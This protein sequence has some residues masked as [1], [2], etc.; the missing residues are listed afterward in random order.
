MALPRINPPRIP[1]VPAAPRLPTAP[2]LPTYAGPK[3]PR[4]ILRPIAYVGVALCV[5]LILAAGGW[6]TY[7]TRD[8]MLGALVLGGLIV[9][10]LLLLMVRMLWRRLRAR[11]AARLS[12]RLGKIGHERPTDARPEEIATNDDLAR[13]FEEGL[14]KFKAAGKSVYD[15]P[16]YLIVGEPGGGKTEAMRHSEIGFP[17]GLHDAMQGAGGTYSMS[18]WFSNRAVLIDTAG[19]L[20]F[21]DRDAEGAL[22]GGYRNVW[23][24]FLK[25]LRD[26][27]PGCPINGMVLV[28]PAVSLLVDPPEEIEAKGRLIRE[29][30]DQIQK[31]LGVRFPVYVVVTKCDKITGFKPFFETVDDPALQHQMLG[32]SNPDGLDAPFD[33]ESVDK[34]LDALHEKLRRRRTVALAQAATRRDVERRLDAVDELYDFPD[35]FRA[36]TDRLRRYLELAF[37]PD[38]WSQPLLLRGI[39][40][41]SSMREGDALD[42]LVSDITGVPP[43]HLPEGRSWAVDKAYFLRDVFV[44]KAFREKGLIVSGNEA[45]PSRVK[46]RHRLLVGGAAAAALAVIGGLF[47]F[48]TR[49]LDRAVVSQSSY[50]SGLSNR[51]VDDKG[52]LSFAPGDGAPTRQVLAANNSGALVYTGDTATNGQALEELHGAAPARLRESLTV[53][54]LFKLPAAALGDGLGNARNAQVR[55]REAYRAVFRGSVATPLI[56]PLLDTPAANGD[57]GADE[58]YRNAMVRVLDYERLAATA[59]KSLQSGDTAAANIALT[60]L[61]GLSLEPLWLNALG[62][63]ATMLAAVDVKAYDEAMR[64]AHG[65]DQESPSETDLAALRQT[66]V[67]FRD[68]MTPD[69]WGELVSTRL[70]GGS[71]AQVPVDLPFDELSPTAADFEAKRQALDE[72]ASRPPPKTRVEYDERATVLRDAISALNTSG[73]E[74]E[75]AQ[76]KAAGLVLPGATDL[77]GAVD[78]REQIAG[79]R[80]N[81]AR[82]AFERFT[83]AP[84]NTVAVTTWQRV[85]R[86]AQ[87]NTQEFET[88]TRAMRERLQ[89][90]P[91]GVGLAGPPD[92]PPSWRQLL[93]AYNAISSAAQPIGDLETGA[94]SKVANRDKRSDLI[95]AIA[96][97]PE[98]VSI[99]ESARTLW[100]DVI[101]PAQRHAIEIAIIEVLPDDPQKIKQLVEA[102]SRSE[103]ES[104]QTGVNRL[105]PASLPLVERGVTVGVDA[106]DPWA[107]ELVAADWG[108]ITRSLNGEGETL[109]VPYLKDKFDPMRKNGLAPYAAEYVNHWHEQLNRAATP[110]L[111][112]WP[113]QQSRGITHG[114]VKASVEQLATLYGKAGDVISRLGIQPSDLTE[115]DRPQEA[116]VRQ[117]GNELQKWNNAITAADPAMAIADPVTRW[118]ALSDDAA[119]AAKTLREQVDH[120]GFVRDYLAGNVNDPSPKERYLANATA[121]FL[122]TLSGGVGAASVTGEDVRVDLRFPLIPSTDLGAADLMSPEQ[123]RQFVESRLGSQIRQDE[124]VKK[125]AETIVSTHGEAVSNAYSKIFGLSSEELRDANSIYQW[126]KDGNR[127]FTMTL[128]S[129]NTQEE[130]FRDLRGRAAISA[131]INISATANQNFDPNANRGV[132]PTLIERASISTAGIDFSAT[133]RLG[134]GTAEPVQ[135][136]NSALSAWR[137]L[138]L[139]D[140]HGVGVEN[141]RIVH[142]EIPL[143]VGNDDLRKPLWIQVEFDAELPPALVKRFGG[144]HTP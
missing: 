42:V 10:G 110:S 78:R 3:P 121:S 22:G 18:W 117:A 70:I 12:E 73:E 97:V 65:L 118:S 67:G 108:A 51:F 48:S 4:S 116:F 5:L 9:L 142:L 139:A 115:T 60:D 45:K 23:Q 88:A 123:L 50:W 112:I 1:T 122:T 113:N 101:Q 24:N 133:E 77:A 132:A 49:Q 15:L 31:Q 64:A 68:G 109:D 105:L 38:Q 89:T 66:V 124:I 41:T 7:V 131:L 94:R 96:K 83:D 125:T 138:D 111:K 25:I 114:Q 103:R 136:P 54:G 93:A 30:F 69:K 143:L 92:G 20:M 91:N 134:D 87:T 90:L 13:R 144:V 86:S 21:G 17:P 127:T 128:P 106:F 26:T 98:P 107:L 36:A 52:T 80:A 11:R 37:E 16:W 82:T 53:P 135:F 8:W 72:I 85:S 34:H 126:L 129:R 120:E 130:R 104:S 59:E 32:W 27:R 47:F 102:Q 14:A 40:F 95:A 81:S 55:T 19:R 63:D 74:V 61:R 62:G 35:A 75:A 43:E 84:Q 29:N 141:G 119:E 137:V 39:Y 28:I 140:N 57:A 76:A 46:R 44:E 33:A 71:S 6:W 58:R 100:S 56:S 2:T 79:A 99:S